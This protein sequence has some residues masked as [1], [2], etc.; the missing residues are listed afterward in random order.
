MKKLLFYHTGAFV[1]VA[2]GCNKDNNDEP[3]N[4]FTYDGSK[5]SL[6]KDLLKTLARM[7]MVPSDWDVY[8]TTDGVTVSEV[9]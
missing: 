6:S 1:F 2:P 8:L 5:Y 3:K 4:E 9:Y 7:G